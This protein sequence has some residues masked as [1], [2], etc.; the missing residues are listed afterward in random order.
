MVL[1]EQ[2]GGP[3]GPLRA[4]QLAKATGVDRVTAWRWLAGHSRPSRLA[5][6]RLH[7]LGIAFQPPPAKPRPAPKRRRKGRR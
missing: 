7:Q 1:N 6:A 3:R 4:S 2:H 5:L